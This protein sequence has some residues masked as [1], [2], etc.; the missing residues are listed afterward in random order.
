M[1]IGFLG[2]GN[3]ASAITLGVAAKFSASEIQC[4]LFDLEPA[5]IDALIASCGVG[6]IEKAGTMADIFSDTDVVLLAVKPYHIKALM[7]EIKEL[8]KPG[9]L[10]LPIIAGI[11]VYYYEEWMPNAAVVRVMPN[12]GAAV[13]RGVAGLVAGSHATETHKAMAEQIFNAVGCSMWITDDLVDAFSALSGSGGAYFYLL[14]QYMAEAGAKLKLDSAQA[15]LMARET[16]IGVGKMLETFPEKSVEQL[17]REITSPKG[18]T[19]AAIETYEAMHFDQVVF[20]AMDASTK[21]GKEIG[22]ENTGKVY[23]AGR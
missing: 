1:R 11:S 12:T 23:E 22:V 7:P 17:R 6:K 19:L 2:A 4:R 14:A 20:A 9:Q 8:L 5:K 15:T 10:L 3:M 18:S 21:R 16:L 13:M